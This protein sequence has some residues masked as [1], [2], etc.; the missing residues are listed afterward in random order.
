M[1]VEIGDEQCDLCNVTS[2][3]RNVKSDTHDAKLSCNAHDR[4]A[5]KK[6]QL[7]GFSGC[8]CCA[9]R[10]DCRE[11]KEEVEPEDTPLVD[12]GIVL[13]ES[14]PRESTRAVIAGNLST[15][16]CVRFQRNAACN[17]H[18]EHIRHCM[19]AGTKQSNNGANERNETTQTRTHQ[20]DVTSTEQCLSQP[21][22]RQKTFLH[23]SV[24]LQTLCFL[25]VVCSRS[26]VAM[27]NKK[28]PVLESRRKHVHKRDW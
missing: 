1:E 10:R 11:W 15:R 5:K 20:I 8:G 26:S 4:S 13:S 28:S 23:M 18:G 19:R 17:G 25:D 3:T 27:F 6:V 24:F 12:F 16:T 21:C 14:G 9:W 2:E 7:M 22:G